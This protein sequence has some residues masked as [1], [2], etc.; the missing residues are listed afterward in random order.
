MNT[1]LEIVIGKEKSVASQFRTFCVL[2][3]VICFII[4]FFLEEKTGIPFISNNNYFFVIIGWLFLCFVIG[5]IKY[6]NE[7]DE[8]LKW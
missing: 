2:G 8:E 4:L 7:D 3:G 5:F 1:P 6:K